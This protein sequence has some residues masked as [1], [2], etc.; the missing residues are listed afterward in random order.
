MRLQASHGLA[1]RRRWAFRSVARW[2]LGLLALG[3]SLA[4]TA[5]QA[6]PIPIVRNAQG[7]WIEDPTVSFAPSNLTLN[8]RRF[9]KLP[10]ENGVRPGMLTM[11]YIPG[12]DRLFVVTGDTG[13]NVYAISANGANVSTIPMFA[14][15]L[16][17][18]ADIAFHPQFN[19]VGAPGYGKLYSIQ[20]VLKPASTVGLQYIGIT[21][22]SFGDGLLAEWTA[23]FDSQGKFTGVNPNSFRELFRIAQF[24]GDHLMGQAEFNP[25]AQPGDEDY[26]LLYVSHGDTYEFQNGYFAAQSGNNGLGKILRVNPLQ[27][28]RA[29]YSIPMS[30]PF[31]DDPT[32]AREIYTLGHRNNHNFSFAQDAK[33][34]AHILVADIGEHRAEEINLV[35]HG[36]ENF[37]WTNFG[38]TFDFPPGHAG[39]EDDQFTFPVAQYAHNPP[40]SHAVAG[41][42]V[43]ANGSQLDGQYVFADFPSSGETFT[44]AFDDAVHA[45][46]TGDPADLDPVDVMRIGVRFDDD[47]DPATPLVQ[48]TLRDVI[49]GESTYSGGNR[50]DVRFGQGP[51]GE[52]YVMNKRN[53]WI[54]QVTNSMATDPADF[55]FDYDVDADDFA[56]WKAGFG[57]SNVAD[58]NGNGRTAGRDFLA[59][60][61]NAGVDMLAQAAA[62]GV[63]EPATITVLSLAA[64]AM[65]YAWRGRQRR[66]V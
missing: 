9:A 51:R 59:W 25:F 6:N 49:R 3:A 4:P 11:N 20:N 26:G 22:P 62:S 21:S 29:P 32:M 16:R 45:V 27:N 39:N 30:N 2:A 40:G 31:I 28:G 37:G 5:C 61:R 64:S 18:S 10:D 38:G 24:S 54:Y 41:G 63:P 56:I 33:G 46:T 13:S 19:Q 7:E 52:I 1:G 43:V 15:N 17:Y 55:D 53:G 36:G 35:S 48:T 34:D 42:Y 60:Q 23:V 8:L 12:D 66:W 58:A 65:H 44:F 14:P 57:E 47:N 50:V